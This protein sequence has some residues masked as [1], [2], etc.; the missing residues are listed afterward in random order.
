MPNLDIISNENPLANNEQTQRI[1]KRFQKFIL[2]KKVDAFKDGKNPKPAK[3]IKALMTL[4]IQSHQ[5]HH[6][7]KYT[8]GSS[9]AQRP[10]NKLSNFRRNY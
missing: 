5:L 2:D 3:K 7:Y 9:A 10:I 8:V 1:E 4:I 6:Y